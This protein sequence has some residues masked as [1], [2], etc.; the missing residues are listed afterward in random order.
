MHDWIDS[1]P[2][3]AALAA[4]CAGA[5]VIGL[6]TEFMRVRTY[7]PELA[8]VQ[9]AHADGIALVDPSRG[10]DLAPLA[11]VLTAG[12]PTLVMHSASEDLVALAP[13]ARAPLAGLFDTQVAAAFAGL[14]AGLGYQRLVADVLG[15]AIDKGETRSNWLARP[16]SADQL[17]YAEVDVAHLVPLHDAL[18]ERLAARGTL[19]WCLEECA[20]L[21]AQAADVAVPRNAHWDFRNGW[22][23]PIERQARLKRLLEWREETARRVN[24]PRLWLFDNPTA[25]ALIESPPADTGALSAR[26]AQQ[27]AFPKREYGALLELLREPLPPH[28]A[29]VEPIPEPLRGEPERTFDRLR[30]AVAARA[31]ALDL[32]PA[33]LASRRVLEDLAR[34]GADLGSLPGWRGQA[35][36]SSG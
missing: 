19:A 7:W 18:R 35:L 11:P 21:A 25:L 9:V 27:K 24:R 2:Q 14:G 23:W 33:L 17:R 22:R 1:T 4:A 3:L 31:Q 20:R 6:D 26:L 30:D 29:E 12:R 5:P 36:S 13:V 15:I 34:T 10:V 32:P 28:A 8:L 16:L